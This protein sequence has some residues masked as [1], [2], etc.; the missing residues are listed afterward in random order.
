MNSDFVLKLSKDFFCISKNMR[1]DLCLNLTTVLR[2]G[3]ED[4]VAAAARA[5]FESVELWADSLEQYL[6]AHS[7][8]D[9]R[10]VLE[11]HRLK[12]LSIGDIESI[13]FCNADQFDELRRR[14]EKLAEVAAAIACPN[15]VAS[16]SVRPRGVD[17]ARIDDEAASAFG[18]LLDIVEPAGVRLALAFR[19]FRW[20]A[21]NSLEQASRTIAAHAGRRAG[22]ALDTFDLHNTGV[23]DGELQGIDPTSIFVLRLS[24][25]ANVPSPILSDTDRVLPGEGVARLDSMLQAFVQAGYSG[26]VSLKILSPNLWSLGADDLAKLVMAMAVQ[27]VPERTKHGTSATER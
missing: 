3:L 24:D 2:A 23:G 10:N 6:R 19:G 9:L 17:E 26:P 1:M 8:S 7:V 14:C 27:Y 12:V 18:K 5:G 4:A 20:C 16:A 21:V 13:T 15:L 25:S 11:E 22:L